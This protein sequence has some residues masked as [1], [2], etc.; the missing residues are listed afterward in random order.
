MDRM[1]EELKIAQEKYKNI[2]LEIQK[3][4]EVIRLQKEVYFFR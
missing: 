4:Q 2:D 1:S 3:D